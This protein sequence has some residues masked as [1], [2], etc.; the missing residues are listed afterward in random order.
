MAQFWVTSNKKS[1][2]IIKKIIKIIA[3]MW[4]Y[5]EKSFKAKFQL[6]PFFVHII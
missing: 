1:P 4:T 3:T 6:S 5:N 2:H